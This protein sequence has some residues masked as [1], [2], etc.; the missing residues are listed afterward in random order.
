MKDLLHDPRLH[1]D[2]E[3]YWWHAIISIVRVKATM[4]V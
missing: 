3:S 4:L 1:T 2:V